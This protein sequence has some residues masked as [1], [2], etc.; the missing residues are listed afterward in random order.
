LTTDLTFLHI[1]LKH[2]WGPH[3]RVILETQCTT[4]NNFN[5]TF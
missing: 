1:I 2:I 3:D 4:G 5:T